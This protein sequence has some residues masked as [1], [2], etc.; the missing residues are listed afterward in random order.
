MSQWPRPG[1]QSEPEIIPP[2]EPLRPR[3]P[4]W[5][6]QDGSAFRYRRVRIAR[7]GPLALLLLGMAV[8]AGL[9]LAIVLLLGA[10]LLWL[11]LLAVIAVAAIFSGVLRRPLR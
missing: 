9:L 10:V 6:F 5:V 1:Q 11:P 3:S 2:G 4:I 8:G 7:P